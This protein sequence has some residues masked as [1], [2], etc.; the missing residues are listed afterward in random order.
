MELRVLRYFLA[1]AREENITKAA[2]F[3]RLTQPTLS[4]QLMQL[5]EEL[6]VK[7]FQRGRH[8][9]ALTNE[10][11]LLRRRAQELVDLADKTAREVSD[12]GRELIGEISIG[13]GE[14]RGMS[15]LSQT[16]RLFQE[17]YPKVVFHI[18]SGSADAVKERLDTGLLDLGLFTEP[19]DVEQYG[20]FRLKEK[21]RWGVLVREDSPLAKLRA[22][23]PR[24]LEDIPLIISGR[25]IVQKELASW[26]GESWESVHPAA[27]FNLGLNAANMVRCGVGA[28]VYLELGVSFDGLRLLPL[29]PKMETGTVLVW[30]KGQVPS[31]AE[32][33]FHDHVKECLKS[34]STE[35]E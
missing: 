3:L 23:T 33:A 6:G 35:N 14:S 28:A 1:V 8:R 12:S 20:F 18:F 16:I 27:T 22:V 17:R 32:A 13:A 21:D 11:R 34:I 2:A 24:D 25:E 7:L 31:P 5:E 15:F 4:R 29:R 9:I 19:V 10:G 30:K 26:F